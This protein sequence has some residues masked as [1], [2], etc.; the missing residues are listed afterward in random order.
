MRLQMTIV[1][2][3]KGLFRKRLSILMVEY[4]ISTFYLS[5]KKKANRPFL[6]HLLQKESKAP[7]GA[8]E[9]EARNTKPFFC[10]SSVLLAPQVL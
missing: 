2:S 8:T 10:S 4:Y 5:S 1:P 3:R 6:K 9:A 7:S